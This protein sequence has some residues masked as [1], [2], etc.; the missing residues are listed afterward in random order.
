MAALFKSE[1]S[2]CCFSEPQLQSRRDSRERC[3]PS[4][5]E[6]KQCCCLLLQSTLRTHRNVI[7][8]KSRGVLYKY[9][10]SGMKEGTGNVGGLPG[11][12]S[13]HCIIQE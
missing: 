6:Q 4:V 8:V 7:H 2:A 5:A 13:S 3:H 1:L 11:C 10:Y 9:M 12:H